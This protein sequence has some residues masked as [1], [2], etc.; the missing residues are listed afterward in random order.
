VIYS[1]A[2]EPVVEIANNNLGSYNI[3]SQFQKE[4][5]LA[6]MNCWDFSVF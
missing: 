5:R 1:T 4:F 2:D 3:D 6:T